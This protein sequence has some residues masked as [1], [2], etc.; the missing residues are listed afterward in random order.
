[1]RLDIYKFGCFLKATT[2]F[3][4]AVFLFGAAGLLVALHLNSS[5]EA[6]RYYTDQQIADEFIQSVEANWPSNRSEVYRALEKMDSAYLSTNE[7][8][9]TKLG[10][11]NRL[12]SGVEYSASSFSDEQAFLTEVRNHG[13]ITADGPWWCSSGKGEL[14][15]FFFSSFALVGAL[16][17]YL[18]VKGLESRYP[19]LR[20]ILN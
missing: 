19:P 9:Q 16:L 2:G 4:A 18:L 7:R 6:V 13:K 1:M 14:F 11:L 5:R 20:H 12:R 10:E 8:D 3:V 17:W 15:V